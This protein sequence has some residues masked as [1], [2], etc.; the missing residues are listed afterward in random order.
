MYT[1]TFLTSE[2][3]IL[4][5]LSQSW[6]HYFFWLNLSQALL[7]SDFLIPI[8]PKKTMICH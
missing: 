7:E 1:V 2:I 8:A 3:K 5:S 4:N 6:F